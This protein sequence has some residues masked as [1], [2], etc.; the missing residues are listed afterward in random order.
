MS[1]PNPA[2]TDW[3]SLWRLGSSAVGVPLPVV[4]GSFVKGVGGAAVW[5]ALT[6][7]DAGMITADAAWHYVGTAGEPAFQDSWA[8]YDAAGTGWTQAR[9]R[10]LS[11]GVVQVQG[12]VNR[13]TMPGTNSPI[14]TLPVGYRPSATVGFT[15]HAN[16]SIN[17]NVVRLDL[18]AAGTIYFVEGLAGAQSYTWLHVIFPAEQ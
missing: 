13:P 15:T 3:V 4:N 16:N 14:F 7:G 6:P 9:F 18:S 17:A 11:T 10:K 1:T 5:T 2:T 12:L 8:N